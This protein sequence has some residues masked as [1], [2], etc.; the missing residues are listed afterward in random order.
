MTRR[1]IGVLCT[2]AVILLLTVGCT[3]AGTIGAPGTGGGTGGRR[4]RPGYL[5][6]GRACFAA[7]LVGFVARAGVV[8]VAAD[9]LGNVWVGAGLVGAFPY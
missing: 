3:K 4:R 9:D 8:P 6:D 7:R 5:G 1:M 2:A